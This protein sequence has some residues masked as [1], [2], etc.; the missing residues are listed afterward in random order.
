MRQAAAPAFACLRV[1]VR[2][3]RPCRCVKDAPTHFWLDLLEQSRAVFRGKLAVALNWGPFTSTNPEIIPQ[4]LDRLDFL[5]LDCCKSDAFSICLAVRLANPQRITM[6]A[7]YTNSVAVPPSRPW[8]LPT[9][10][11]L[12]EGWSD[13][14]VGPLSWVEAIANFSKAL[15]DIDI[16][17]TEV[18]YQS[19]PTPW[20]NPAGTSSLNPRDCTV[21]SLCVS[22]AAQA[23]SYEVLFSALYP[24]AWF[25]G[26]CECSD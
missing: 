8:Q 13:P 7:D 12:L 25:K 6:I 20:L 22:T 14:V 5:G 18:G 4:W 10:E 3:V 24:Q 21:Q 16:V 23:L 11:Q 26:F 1:P 2:Q 9:V 19:K 17:C 15:D